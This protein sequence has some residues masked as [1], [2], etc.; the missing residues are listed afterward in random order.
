MF[1][2]YSS[3][4]VIELVE[5]HFHTIA[6]ASGVFILIMEYVRPPIEPSIDNTKKVQMWPFKGTQLYLNR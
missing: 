3:L 6:Y 4:G 5:W 1:Q 2:V